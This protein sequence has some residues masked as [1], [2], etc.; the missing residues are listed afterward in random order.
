MKNPRFTNKSEEIC[1]EVI[2]LS[3]CDPWVAPRTTDALAIFT[4]PP[5]KSYRN[6]VMLGQAYYISPT[7]TTCCRAP[8]H[9]TTPAAPQTP[10]YPTTA[11]TTTALPNPTQPN[12]TQL[13][14]T[15]RQIRRH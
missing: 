2:K 10:H 15:G 9:P 11:V 3:P 13:N 7:V 6:F 4:Q 12:P 14:P 5:Q 1:R 8:N